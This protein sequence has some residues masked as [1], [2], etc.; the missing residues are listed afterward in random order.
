MKYWVLTGSTQACWP[1][2]VIKD[3][4]NEKIH[5]LFLT[6]NSNECYASSSGSQETEII[7]AL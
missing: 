5:S 1:Q 4:Y 6:F 7:V 2:I 3:I